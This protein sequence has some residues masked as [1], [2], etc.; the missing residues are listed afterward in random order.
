MSSENVDFFESTRIKFFDRI[1][2]S[3]P[4]NNISNVWSGTTLLLLKVFYWS[5]ILTGKMRSTWSQVDI[6]G[7]NL[8]PR[9]LSL[10]STFRSGSDHTTKVRGERP[11]GLLLWIVWAYALH[12]FLHILRMDGHSCFY[13]KIPL[14]RNFFSSLIYSSSI[15]YSIGTWALGHTR[16][17]RISSWGGKADL[18]FSTHILLL[19]ILLPCKK[20][21]QAQLRAAGLIANKYWGICGTAELRSYQSCYMYRHLRLMLKITSF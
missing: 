7:I 12:L 17:Q 20:K 3:N 14:S 2:T 10:I 21:F 1:Y 19:S 8:M 15:V 13:L 9:W 18:L 4:I 16:S 6:I 5:Y 11:M